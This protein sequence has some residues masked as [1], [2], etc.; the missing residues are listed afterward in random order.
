M[1]FPWTSLQIRLFR[2]SNVFFASLRDASTATLFSATFRRLRW[3]RWRRRRRHFLSSTGFEFHFA[4]CLQHLLRLLLFAALGKNWVLSGLR[5]CQSLLCFFF[6]AA[7]PN[8]LLFYFLCNNQFVLII[9]HT[10][11]V[12][13]TDPLVR[14]KLSKHVFDALV[15]L[16]SMRTWKMKKEVLNTLNALTWTKVSIRKLL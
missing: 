11:F 16:L 5:R 2:C 3:R 7:L 13:I 12:I 8:E 10:L 9:Q 15:S 1:I 14:T 6:I 4:F